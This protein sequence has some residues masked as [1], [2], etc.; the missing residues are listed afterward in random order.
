MALRQLPCL[1]LFV[2]FF[3]STSHSVRFGS[4]A[5]TL[6]FSP[7]SNQQKESFTRIRKSTY[8]G[9]DDTLARHRRQTGNDIGDNTGP[10]NVDV[11][12]VMSLEK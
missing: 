3:V 1:L 5:K 8:S 6:F 11:T 10:T 7:G 9:S 2:T 12:K 4:R